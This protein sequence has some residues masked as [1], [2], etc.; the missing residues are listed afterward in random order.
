MVEVSRH[1]TVTER[2]AELLAGL[3]GDIGTR[4]DRAARDPDT[5]SPLFLHALRRLGH[6]CVLDPG[7]AS[8]ET[9]DSLVFAL[10]VG[11]AVFAVADAAPGTEVPCRLGGEVVTLRGTGPVRYATAETWLTTMW[12][13]VLARD[14]DAVERHTAVPV[15]LLKGSGAAEPHYLVHMVRM[16]QLFFRLESGADRELN[17]AVGHGDPAEFADPAAREAAARIRYPQQR[18]F[19]YFLVDH[20]DEQFNDALAQA[21]RHHRAYW[22]AT[23]DRAAS[24][25]GYL[26]LGPLALTAVAHDAGTAITVRSDYLPPALYD[27]SAFAEHR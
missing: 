7:G 22:T 3:D 11:S 16:L 21:L 27:G 18:L 9:W 17:S 1:D 2:S 10:D 20:S 26:A 24:P 8:R 15:E 5:L 12:L 13:A 23:G 19:H 6:R 25:A 4:V 14:P